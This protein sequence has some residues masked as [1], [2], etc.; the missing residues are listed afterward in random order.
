MY[1]KHR[2]VQ[3]FSIPVEN[4]FTKIDK[5]GNDTVVTIS[6]EIKFIVSERFMASLLSILADNIAE[7]IHRI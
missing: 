6:Y 5:D 1:L 7:G 3:N 4:E 2:K